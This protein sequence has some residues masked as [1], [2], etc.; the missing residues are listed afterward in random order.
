MFY[1]MLCY[2]VLGAVAG[3]RR[4]AG[5]RATR[6]RAPRCL[7]TYNVAQCTLQAYYTDL[8]GNTPTSPAV[9]TR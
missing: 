7:T 6:L 1:V 4:R 3:M 8:Q 9:P 2:G 5:R